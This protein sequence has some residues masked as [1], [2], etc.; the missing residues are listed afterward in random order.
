MTL[1]DIRPRLLSG[2][3]LTAEEI[4]HACAGLLDEGVPV[5]SRAEILSVLH[6]RGETAEEVAGFVEVLLDRAQPVPFPGEGCLD[7][8]GTGGDRAGLFNVST[9]VMLVAAACGARVVKHG[10]RGITSRSGGAD[11]LEALGVRIDLPPGGAAAALGSAGCCFLFAPHYHPAFQAV[12]PVRKFLAEKGET[13]IFNMLGP[14]LNP[15]RPSFQLAGVFDGRLLPIYSRVFA[16]LGR[17]RAWAVHG[18]GTVSL[19]EVSPLDITEVSAWEEDSARDFLI[20]PQDFGI[21]NI[22]A[23]DLAGGHAAFNAGIIS[24]VVAGNLRNGARTIVVMN[25]GAALAIAGIAPDLAAGMKLAGSA[26]DNGSARDVL[27][28]LRAA[29]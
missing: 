15:A 28:R 10:N 18:T 9:A 24:D 25:A 22:H 2:T 29:R 27:D 13:S 20:R 5:E 23:G 1:D 14:L 4:R 16:L 21:G 11:V 12:A 8:C 26:I 7:V 3:P 19:D 17:R 6:K